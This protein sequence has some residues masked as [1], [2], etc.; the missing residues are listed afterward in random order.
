MVT[1]PLDGP[2]AQHVDR[3]VGEVIASRDFE[4]AALRLLVAAD[5]G[6]VIEGVR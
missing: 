4:T 3:I 5:Y 1:T 6:D 2:A